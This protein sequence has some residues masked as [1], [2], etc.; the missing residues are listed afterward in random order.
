[1]S[2]KSEW[3]FDDAQRQTTEEPSNPT[4]CSNWNCQN[5]GQLCSINGNRE[6]IL[7]TENVQRQINVRTVTVCVSLPV[8]GARSSFSALY[9]KK[10]LSDD[11]VTEVDDEQANQLNSVEHSAVAELRKKDDNSG[12]TQGCVSSPLFNT[13]WAKCNSSGLAGDGSYVKDVDHF[14]ENEQGATSQ[15]N[16]KDDGISDEEELV[17][18][19]QNTGVLNKVNEAIVDRVSEVADCKD[20]A[21]ADVSMRSDHREISAFEMRQDVPDSC[22]SVVNADSV[23]L[24]TDP[25][26]DDVYQ[27]EC[28]EVADV[29]GQDVVS[30]STNSYE[31]RDLS[32]DCFI[33]PGTRSGDN[34]MT[35]STEDAKSHSDVVTSPEGFGVI[36]DGHSVKKESSDI[37]NSIETLQSWIDSTSANAQLKTSADGGVRIPLGEVEQYAD[38]LQNKKRELDQL[39]TRVSELDK[40]D[41]NALCDEWHRLVSIHAQLHNL[42]ATLNRLASETVC[43]QWQLLYM[44]K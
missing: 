36:P 14:V 38:E 33:S 17:S 29:G 15:K 40:S 22:D 1:M 35:T 19:T 41:K 23:L 11:A 8:N 25:K 32:S 37:A 12:M 21:S 16:S 2:F 13:G 5:G 28:R 9:S 39:N 44:L 24:Q 31:V 26:V 30:T 42:S 20:A 3:N 4:C 43:I 7:Q 34:R 6:S 18:A 27:Q 10:G